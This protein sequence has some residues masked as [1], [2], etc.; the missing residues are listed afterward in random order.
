MKY[1][2]KIV[3]FV[4]ALSMM[5]ILTNCSDDSE[6]GAP[7]ISYVRITD[8]ASSDSLLIAAG[9]GQMIAIIGRNLQNTRQL[10]IND[11]R[12]TLTATLIS[13]KSIITR[14]PDEFPKVVNNQLR[15]VFANGSELTHEFEV[16]V[17]DPL[18]ESM[19]SEYV[20]DGEEA[21]IYGDFF[22]DPITV[23]FPG[24]QT[25]EI[26]SI[27]EEALTFKVPAG[28]TSGPLT[29][30]TNFGTTVSTFHFR[31]QRNIILNYDDLTAAGSWRAGPIASDNG[32]D[33]NYLRLFGTLNANARNEDNFESQF[34]G[35][36]R[37]GSPTN[38]VP[39]GPL[40]SLVLKFEARVVNWYGSVLQVCWGPYDNAGNQEVWA[41]L[42]GRGIWAPW[43][44]LDENYTTEGEWIT[45]VMPLT[46]MIYRHEQQGGQNVW[47]P[48]MEFDRTNTGTLSF[49][50]IATPEASASPVDIHIDNVRIVTE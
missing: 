39:S 35:H 44:V 23:T 8:P 22:F 24:G 2:Y 47:L 19:K 30:T 21:V 36:T 15:L 20:E 1:R 4:I 9:P 12:A 45:V 33:G 41:N 50:V 29:V 5:G 27:E 11:Q 13:D 37:P 43:Q 10:W 32:I 17:P 25:A 34:W 14:I 46:E 31:D 7:M 40:E 42:N 26:V 6:G 28:A 16:A 48:N 3:F 49:W 18:L 38:L